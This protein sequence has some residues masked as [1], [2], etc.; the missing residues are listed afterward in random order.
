MEIANGL[1]YGGFVLFWIVVIV[2][3][4]AAMIAISNMRSCFDTEKN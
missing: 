4:A 2:G 3:I 1:L